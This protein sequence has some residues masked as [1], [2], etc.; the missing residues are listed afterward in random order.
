MFA[1]S[2]TLFHPIDA[3]SPLY[4]VADA[5]LLASEMNSS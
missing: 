1:L 4:G 2:W 5:E 3:D